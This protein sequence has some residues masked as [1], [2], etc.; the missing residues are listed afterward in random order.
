[1][2]SLS[3][4]HE[5]SRKAGVKAAKAN[6]MPFVV[7]QE[8]LDDWKANGVRSFPFPFIGDYQPPGWRKVDSLFCDASGFG[9][10]D[11]PALTIPQLL[12]K[13]Q[14]GKGY[15]ITECGQFQVYLGVFEREGK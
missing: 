13:L 9:A 12:E 3:A 5:E 6:R 10:P 2:M 4:I 7:E 15:A 8:D 11:E 14:V 1:M